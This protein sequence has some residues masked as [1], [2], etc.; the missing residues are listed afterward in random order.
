[1]L[2]R[3]RSDDLRDL[4]AI[5]VLEAIGTPPARLTRFRER[6][7]AFVRYG[8]ER[9]VCLPFNERVRSLTGEQSSG[10]IS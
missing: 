1:M 7:D 9:F 5:E 10:V 8:V 4:R 2:A 3:I 6:Y